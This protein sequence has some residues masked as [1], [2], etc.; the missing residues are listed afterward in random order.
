MKDDVQRLQ[1]RLRAIQW[2]GLAI[3]GF[4]VIARFVLPWHDVTNGLLIGEAG[5]AG[6]VWSMIRQGHLHD[7]RQGAAL[8][9]SGIVGYF[10]RMLLLVAVIVIAIK[11]PHVH[12]LAALVGYLLGFALVV[13]GLYRFDY[14]AGGR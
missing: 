3:M 13:A 4:T 8:M 9:V 12:V 11:L 5:G 14:R 6:A 1:A 10:I 2:A 7:G